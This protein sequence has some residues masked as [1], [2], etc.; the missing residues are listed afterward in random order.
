M[1]ISCGRVFDYKVKYDEYVRLRAE[2]RE[3]QLRAYENQQK[4]I[5][6]I[7]EFIERF[8]YKP[9][10]PCRYRAASNSLKRWCR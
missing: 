10:R 8:R 7:K 4:E 6:D 1:E 5:A 3:Q 9:L 2:R